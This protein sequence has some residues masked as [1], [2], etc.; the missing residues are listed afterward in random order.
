MS[1]LPKKH[2]ACRTAG[3]NGQFIFWASA[4]E[5][6]PGEGRKGRR[7]GILVNSTLSYKRGLWE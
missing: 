2:V 3:L 4:E 5:S 6:S 1:G 7:K